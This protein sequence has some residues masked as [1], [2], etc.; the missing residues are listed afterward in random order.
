[1]PPVSTNFTQAIDAG[2][3]RSLRIAVGNVLGELLMEHE[4][5]ER[6]EVKMT[7]GERCIL[8]TKLVAAV[9]N[10]FMSDEDDEMRIGCFERT[11][12]LITMHH[13]DAHDKVK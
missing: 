10:K 8:T 11:G 6:W 1:M 9:N 3:G 2:Y 5:M 12:N 7:V 13:L 4:N